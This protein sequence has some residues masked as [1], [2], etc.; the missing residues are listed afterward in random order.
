M[1]LF[2]QE[3]S[4]V[5]QSMQAEATRRKAAFK[6]RNEFFQ[7]YDRLYFLQHYGTKSPGAIEGTVGGKKGV[8]AQVNDATVQVDTMKNLIG[9]KE[10]RIKVFPRWISG[11]ELEAGSEIE[12]WLYAVL[13]ANNDR[14]EVAELLNLVL[15]DV[16][17]LGWG[18]VYSY[19]DNEVVSQ[20]QMML[21]EVGLTI[22][23]CPI[24]LEKISP[25]FVYPELGGRHGRWRSH[26]II[27]PKKNAQEVAEEW[28][29][30]PRVLREATPEAKH[31]QTVEYIVYWGWEYVEGGWYVVNCVMADDEIIRPPTI[32]ENYD[33]LPITIFFCVPTGSPQWEYTSLSILFPLHLHIKLLD[34][35]M[36]RLH[37]QV[38]I[39]TNLPVIHVKSRGGQ[40]SSIKIDTGIYNLLELEPGEDFKFPQWPGN[41]PDFHALMNIERQ[42]IQEG[43]FSSLAL[44]EAIPI[45]GIAASRLWEANYVK[46]MTPT[47]SYS[48]AL[49][50]LL[51]KIKSLAVNFAPQMPISLLSNYP[52]ASGNVI[53]T[54]E[55]LA[56]Y[57]LSPELFGDL[58]MDEFRM[59]ALA[60]QF[61][62]LGERSPLS[63]ETLLED[64]LGIEQPEEE[65]A[66]KLV[67]VA[68]Q[69]KMIRLMQTWQYLQSQG[70]NI[71]LEF[72]AQV[73]GTTGG[74]P[75]T[76][77]APPSQAVSTVMSPYESGISTLAEEQF[78]GQPPYEQQGGFLRGA[79]AVQGGFAGGAGR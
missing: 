21:P 38:D 4:K 28:K 75:P 53:L 22:T 13:E 56:P 8:I 20:S 63:M 14:Y 33:A 44:G 65:F 37:K 55:M 67:D 58:P 45:S 1:N 2:G 9:V 24:I 50:S 19:W 25:Y 46:L 62:Q 18:A 10:L 60:L 43:G 16:L 40:G 74:A 27:E 30:T 42:K 5:R 71:P 77:G 61:S 59:K 7:V 11:E 76:Q 3:P 12:R 23:E 69:S 36:S 41:P 29:V 34:H 48:R 72:L 49:K 79:A 57:M 73:E 47:K 78:Q 52:K 35:L 54:G 70:Y 64:Y 15:G 26:L 39:F 17:R 31:L 51:N 68:R 32:M 66:K 6:R